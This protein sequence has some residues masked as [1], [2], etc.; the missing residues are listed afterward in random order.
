MLGRFRMTA[1]D[2][3]DEYKALGGEVFGRP[4]HLT[5]LNTFVIRRPKYDTK[6]LEGIIQQVCKRRN[7]KGK[8]Q[9]DGSIQFP[10]DSDLCR[11]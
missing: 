2:C 7:E 8:D 4:R 9:T 11:T 10:F 6:R 3:L 1:K 5:Q